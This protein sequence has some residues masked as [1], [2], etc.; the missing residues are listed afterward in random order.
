MD[1]F[2]CHV[3]PKASLEKMT[4]WCGNMQTRK[5]SANCATRTALRGKHGWKQ[6]TEQNIE[7]LTCR[8]LFVTVSGVLKGSATF[9]EVRR[10]YWRLNMR[11]RQIIWSV[12]PFL[13]LPSSFDVSIG[14]PSFS[15]C[16]FILYSLAAVFYFSCLCSFVEQ[17]IADANPE[18]RSNVTSDI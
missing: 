12:F 1:C 5:E 3:V 17:N 18:I 2:A 13:F 8:Y 11:N 7:C 16:L 10:L 9:T 15:F 6:R 4:P 14:F